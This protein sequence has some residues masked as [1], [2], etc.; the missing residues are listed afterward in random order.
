MFIKNLR[1][2]Y[3]QIIFLEFSCLRGFNL[4]FAKDKMYFNQFSVIM[5]RISHERLIKLYNIKVFKMPILIM[6]FYYNYFV[7]QF[8]L[9]FN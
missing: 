5:H 8:S 6:Q 7:Y 3:K 2:H 1:K 9:S 4:N